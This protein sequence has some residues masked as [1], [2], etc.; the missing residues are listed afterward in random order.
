VLY[1]ELNEAWLHESTT[2]SV[3]YRS[4]TCTGNKRA[5]GIWPFY[6]VTI[7]SDS[8]EMSLCRCPCYHESRTMANNRFEMKS[9]MLIRQNLSFRANTS[10]KQLVNLLSSESINQNQ[11]KKIKWSKIRIELSKVYIEVVGTTCFTKLTQP[12][13]YAQWRE[14]VRLQQHDLARHDHLEL[15]FFFG[16]SLRAR[17]CWQLHSFPW[18]VPIHAVYVA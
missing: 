7:I 5:A 13:C 6:D 17:S 8:V 18:A 1:N 11:Q 10:S 2:S 15:L 9:K 3:S 14:E 16:W 12:P 4:E